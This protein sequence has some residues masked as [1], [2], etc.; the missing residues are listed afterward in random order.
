MFAS[1]STEKGR[2]ISITWVVST[3]SAFNSFACEFH[4]DFN[5][6]A[7][8]ESLMCPLP[9]HF[10][11]QTFSGFR[12]KTALHKIRIFIRISESS[13]L[14]CKLLDTLCHAKACTP[15]TSRYNLM[16]WSISFLEQILPALQ[17]GMHKHIVQVHIWIWSMQSIASALS[18][19]H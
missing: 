12:C 8:W 14:K 19:I 10:I 4:D 5:E 9:I 2:P 7:G 11:N 15:N 1:I 17:T 18:L 13:L 3:H 16:I 6:W